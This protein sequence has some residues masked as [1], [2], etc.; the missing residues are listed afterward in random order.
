MLAQINV[1][2]RF[3]DVQSARFSSLMRDV[4]IAVVVVEV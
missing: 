3:G 4:V 1:G 2:P